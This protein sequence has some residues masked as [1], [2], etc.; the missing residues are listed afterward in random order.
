M[1]ALGTFLDEEVLVCNIAQDEKPYIM[2]DIE[3]AY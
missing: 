3:A 1:E 2:Q